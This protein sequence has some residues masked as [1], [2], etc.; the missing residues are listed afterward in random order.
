MES[1]QKRFNLLLV[2]LLVSA[3]LLSV[4]VKA[5]PFSATWN[6]SQTSANSSN[7]SQVK[8]PL[9]SVGT[10]NFFVDWGDGNSN[11]I[12]VWNETNVTHNYAAQGIK[13]INISGTIVGFKFGYGN[14]KDRL[15]I[16]NVLSWGDLR[17]GNSGGYFGTCSNLNSSATDN[18]N[19]TGTTD[20]SYMFFSAFLFNGNI[21]GWNTSNITNMSVMFYDASVFNGNINSWDTSS[22]TD[23]S[24]MFY[25]ASA[26]NQNLSS[27]NTS[28]I[29]AM[30]NMF[31]SASSFNGDISSWDT[32]EV[33]TMNNMFADSVFNRD[34]GGW[35]TSSVTKMHGMFADAYAFNQNIGGWN[36]GSV[37][38]MSGMFY[39]AYA[40]NQ[41]LSP[42]NTSSVTNMTNMFYG[43]TLSVANYDSL[44]N[45]WSGRTQQNAVT[46]S[47]GNSKYSNSG[48]NGRNILTNTYGWS[49]TDGGWINNAP[50]NV[51]GKKKNETTPTT[52][53]PQ[54]LVW[55]YVI[56]VAILVIIAFFVYGVIKKRR[57]K[58]EQ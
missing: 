14:D 27:W 21:S 11:T 44:L 37:N 1:K 51:S 58:R 9:E 42:W 4:S 6:T 10:Y 22:V 16:L 13:T 35:N 2:V 7:A 25:Y 15:K 30:A 47:G 40:F 57:K 54:T 5:T 32:S 38:D 28:S 24:G 20:L 39:D 34:I 3:T 29:T 53:H 50:T 26:F 48:L 56:L 17:V 8:L 45:G 55:A 43:V 31:R 19:L 46:F 33:T 49:I 23:M 52:E 12:T 41:N 36:T 18:L